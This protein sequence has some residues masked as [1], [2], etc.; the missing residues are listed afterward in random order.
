MRTSTRPMLKARE[1]N[2]MPTSSGRLFTGL[3]CLALVGLLFATALPSSAQKEGYE[4]PQFEQGLLVTYLIYSGLPNPTLVVTDPD[5]V[6]DLQSRLTATVESG[7]RIEGEGPEPVLGYN[8][9]MIEDLGTSER[10]D[11]TFYVVKN[12]MLRVEGGNPEDPAARSTTVAGEAA[13]IENLLIALGV[14]SGT[15][16]E[17]EISELRD[18]KS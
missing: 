16:N 7:A 11:S 4:E 18:P 6:A 9:I 1:N 13:E 15:I 12:D 10:E 14:E 8:G 2:D 3:V 5:R 17:A